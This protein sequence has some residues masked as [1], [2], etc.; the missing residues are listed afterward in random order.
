MSRE[1]ARQ[2]LGESLSMA[3]D[4]HLM[5]D[6]PLGAFLSGGIDSNIIARLMADRASRPL[7]T[8]SISFPDESQ[9]DEGLR[10]ARA[11]RVLGAEHQ[12]IEC[13][14]SDIC[15]LPEIA[16]HLDEPI[17]DAI[18]VPMYVL[19]REAS[20]HVKVVLSGEGAD[21]LLA[22]YL[23]HRQIARLARARRFSPAWAWVALAAT[24]RRMP[25]ALLERAFDYPA[26]L[27]T[28]G[29]ERI[30][31]L[32]SQSSRA[33]LPELLR[34][35]VTLFS[36]TNLRQAAVHPALRE[37][38][39]LERWGAALTSGTPLQR[40]LA[41]HYADWLPDNILMKL[42]KMTMAHSLE[43]RVPFM[44]EAVIQAAARIPDR[45]KVHLRSTKV[46]LRDFSRGLLPSEIVDS[47]K[48]AFYLPLVSYWA[49]RPFQDLVRYTLDPERV[50]KRGLFSHDWIADRLAAP[51][52]AGFL[53][54]RQLFAI[55][56]LELWF[57]RYCPDASWSTSHEG[58]AR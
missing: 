57:D 2:C 27:G 52:S 19:A 38:V 15:A 23:F 44:D 29:R 47:P 30:A 54:L 46:A 41:A 5:S 55:V 45:Y 28:D 6:V 10:A 22:G 58:K 3:V 20:K 24:F 53:P 12:P 50:K 25:A 42:D 26:S 49:S 35:S 43:G 18:V 8:F 13:R 56:M 21:E 9:N 17:G 31:D 16:W 48:R 34:A 7:R 1:D 37:G 14:T 40:L 4:R 32:L 36:D 11:A 33:G 39:D 51:P